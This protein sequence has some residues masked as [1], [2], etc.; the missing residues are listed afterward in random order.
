MIIWRYYWCGDDELYE[1]RMIYIYIY[2]SWW[3]RYD[4]AVVD[5]DDYGELRRMLWIW[6]DDLCDDDD[7]DDDDDDTDT[8]MGMMINDDYD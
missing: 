6:H 4:D 5:G 3:W 2:A 1:I 7:D 8:L